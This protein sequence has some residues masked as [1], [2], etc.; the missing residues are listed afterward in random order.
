VSVTLALLVVAIWL[1]A[2][3]S[4]AKKVVAAT[5]TPDLGP[6]YTLLYIFAALSSVIFLAARKPVVIVLSFTMLIAVY[7]ALIWSN[8]IAKIARE[9]HGK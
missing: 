1:P 7:C 3:I 6:T 9:S 8:Y 2:N 5:K 4:V